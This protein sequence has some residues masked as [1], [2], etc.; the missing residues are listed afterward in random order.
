MEKSTDNLSS[1]YAE[2]TKL[3]HSDTIICLITDLDDTILIGSD[4]DA[5]FHPGDDPR[6]VQMVPS[7]AKA[8]REIE[9]NGGVLGVITNRGGKDAANHLRH[10]GI[11]TARIIGTYGFEK[12]IMKEK[13]EDDVVTIDDRFMKHKKEVTT[14]LQTLRTAIVEELGEPSYDTGADVIFPTNKNGITT[15]EQAPLLIQ[16]KGVSFSSGFPLGLANIYIMNLMPQGTGIRER[17][18]NILEMIIKDSPPLSEWGMGGDIQS[19]ELRQRFT[20]GFE[21]TIKEG[22]GFAM[23]SMID[24]IEREEG[25]EVGLILYSGDSNPDAQA[26]KVA[27]QIEKERLGRLS[28]FGIWVYGPAD[29]HEIE[30]IADIHVSDVFAYANILQQIARLLA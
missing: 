16:Q 3:Q 30:A 11:H 19:P 14:I 20:R 8:L 21:P 26:I 10:N 15:Q 7:S 12:Y 28:T 4:P 5:G 1:L 18:T 25:K 17:I 24:D 23:R 27:K 22:K 29:Q 13:S 6:R 2:I 9:M